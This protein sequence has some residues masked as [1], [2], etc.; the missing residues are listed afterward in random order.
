MMA[1][2]LMALFRQ[3]ILN[4]KTQHTP[5]TLRFKTLA[6]GAYFEKVDN[7]IILKLALNLKRREWFDGLWSR[8]AKTPTPFQR[9][10]A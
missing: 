6:I 9:S 3:F 10:I 2:N 5:S 4:S 1:Y 8:V 7:T